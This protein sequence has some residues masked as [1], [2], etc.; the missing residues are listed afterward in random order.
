MAQLQ[1]DISDEQLDVLQRLAE[2]RQ[3]PVSTLIIQ[4]VE[5]LEH[6]GQPVG[7]ADDDV[8][9]AY[10]L[11]RINML[12]G[13]FDWLKDEPDLYTLEDGEPV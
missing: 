2:V 5:F 7:D 6:G 12:G 11:S 9:D 3:L 8:L 10:A 1:I 4:Y 13:A